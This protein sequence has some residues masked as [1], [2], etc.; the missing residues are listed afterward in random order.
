[1][2]RREWMRVFGG[3]A[4]MGLSG[5]GTSS[6]GGSGRKWTSEALSSIDTVIQRNGCRGWG[7]WEQGSLK[8]SWR[9]QESGGILSITKV[10]AALACA[11]AAGEGW[12]SADEK[13]ALTISE[14]QGDGDK[15]AV[16]VQMLLQMT[17]GL[18]G[19]AKALYRGNISDKG[20]VAVGLRLVDSPGAQFRYGPA[21]W[22]VLA[23]LLQRKT[24]A[25]G[26]T[27]EKFLHRGVMRPIG[28]HSRDWRS[29]GKG[30]FFL[31]TGAELSVTDLG[32]LGRTLLDL[33]SGRDT[34]GFFA[35]DF[36]TMTRSSSANPIFGGGLWR[37]RNAGR[38]RPVE[39]EDV[40]D[41]PK[42]ASFWRNACLSNRQPASMVSL[43][44]SAGQRIFIWPDEGRVVARLGFSRSWKDLP[45]MAVL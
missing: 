28:L 38:G 5:C 7:A 20:K 4:A 32:R 11:K 3:G 15:E 35:R 29:D 24:V 10:L 34:A 25:R 33:L 19:G 26:E 31:S 1:M 18:E 21:C 22:E 2:K 39:I 13:V 6:S 45:L 36:K 9:T 41:P 40:L 17:A 27:L 30:R 14:W 12:L 8:E 44:G 42:D 23:E 37:N 16:T 43:V